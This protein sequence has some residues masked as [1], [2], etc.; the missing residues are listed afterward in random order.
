MV[1]WTPLFITQ[2]KEFRVTV[3]SHREQL[4]CKPISWIPM[5]LNGTQTY[6]TGL[7]WSQ[8]KTP[9]PDGP[10]PPPCLLTR[11]AA[12]ASP[13]LT[14]T[15]RGCINRPCGGPSLTAWSLCVTVV[16]VMWLGSVVMVAPVPVVGVLPVWL[17]PP[18]SV[19]VFPWESGAGRDGRPD[20]T[21]TQRELMKRKPYR[22]HSRAARQNVRLTHPPDDLNRQTVQSQHKRKSQLYTDENL[23]F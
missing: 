23:W 7:W 20:D 3:T 6:L 15:R 12:A 4:N 2:S 1:G 5:V 16:L 18:I 13:V 22:Y 8:H 14:L 10:N 9:G 21:N 11:P 17:R 19:F